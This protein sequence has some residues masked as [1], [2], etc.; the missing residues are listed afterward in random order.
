MIV[1]LVIINVKYYF[2]NFQG[3]EYL[4]KEIL[5]KFNLGKVDQ[6]YRWLV[7]FLKIWEQYDQILN[8]MPW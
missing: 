4:L 1:H 3:K 8:E 7:E 2:Q 5:Y 6:K